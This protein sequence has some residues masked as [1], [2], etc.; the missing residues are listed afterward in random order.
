MRRLARSAAATRSAARLDGLL[1]V[2][3]RHGV[4][5]VGDRTAHL[6]GAVAVAPRVGD[7][8]DVRVV[9]RAHPDGE[10]QRAGLVRD[11]PHQPRHG[12]QREPLAETGVGLPRPRPGSPIRRA[13]RSAVA[14]GAEASGVMSRV[15]LT[16]ARGK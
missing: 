13:S 3:R 10:P 9:G 12:P 14:V 4:E 7:H 6:L 1:D 15:S 16:A 5:H 2:G 11:R 8:D